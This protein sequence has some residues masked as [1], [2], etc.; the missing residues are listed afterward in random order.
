MENKTKPRPSISN[1]GQTCELS[2]GQELPTIRVLKCP[3]MKR[4]YLARVMVTFNLCKLARNLD[5]KKG[6]ERRRSYF[7]LQNDWAY[8]CGWDT[9]SL[10]RFPWAPST[11]SVTLSPAL[12]STGDL[13]QKRF[14][15]KTVKKTPVLSSRD[16]GAWLLSKG[17]KCLSISYFDL[18][19]ILEILTVWFLSLQTS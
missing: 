11:S 6:K 9:G 16:C 2:G 12:P 13:A 18:N 19:E 15:L 3:R 10:L 5:N 8:E 7:F 14:P 17:H 4:L 1:K